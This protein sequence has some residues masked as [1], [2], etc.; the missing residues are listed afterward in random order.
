MGC[1]HGKIMGKYCIHTWVKS[2][3][4]W[5]N[6]HGMFIGINSRNTVQTWA[7]TLYPSLPFSIHQAWSAV[8]RSL[9][10]LQMAPNSNPC[11]FTIVCIYSLNIVIADEHEH[12]SPKKIMKLPVTCEMIGE[13]LLLSPLKG[14]NLLKDGFWAFG[15]CFWREA[16]PKTT[17]LMG[18][19]NTTRGDSTNSSKMAMI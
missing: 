17:T 6:H 13:M 4:S 5:E 7:E 3:S 8:F 12:V 16:A 18:I 1:F 2:V 10:L 14:K 19:G 11:R 15:R 9:Q